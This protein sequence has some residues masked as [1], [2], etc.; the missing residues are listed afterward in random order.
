[1]DANALTEIVADERTARVLLALTAEPAHETTGRLIADL[2]PTETAR[3]VLTGNVPAG[4]DTDVVHAWRHAVGEG[5]TMPRLVHAAEQTRPAGMEVLIPGDPGWPTGLDDLGHRAPPALWVKG[6]VLALDGPLT[7]RI[8]IVG[9]RAATEY[10]EKVGR[11]LANDLA[12]RG[13]RIVSGGAYGID[14]AAHR[15]ALAADR[16]TIAVLPGGL[17]HPYPTGHHHVFAAIIRNGGALVSERPPGTR[18]GRATFLARNRLIVALTGATVVVE[19]A[20]RSG[21]MHAASQALALGRPLGAVPGP[22]TSV[23]SGGVHELLKKGRT[24]VITG[25]F[26]VVH[27]LEPHSV[28][29]AAPEPARSI[30]ATHAPVAGTHH[31]PSK[32]PEGP[33]L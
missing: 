24:G 28:I 13:R 21:A 8:A 20:Y 22:I 27:L 2:G 25:A 17:D 6:D 26:D 15:G 19:T 5:M 9:S 7:D 10:G 16:V 30:E 23:S 18:V 31:E 14:A 12:L 1:M 4:V 33:S 29:S 3:I 32:G 11:E